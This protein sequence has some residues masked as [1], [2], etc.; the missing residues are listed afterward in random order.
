MPAAKTTTK[1]TTKRTTTKKATPKAKETSPL[2]GLLA[3]AVADRVHRRFQALA[4]RSRGIGEEVHLS[5][6][7]VAEPADPDAQVGRALL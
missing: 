5:R 7:S 2:Q 1:T 4:A 6:I 3:E